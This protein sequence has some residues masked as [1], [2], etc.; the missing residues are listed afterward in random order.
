MSQTLYKTPFSP[1]Y[2]RDALADFKKPRTLVFSALMVA[3]CVALSYL[4][5]IPIVDNVRVTWGFLARALCA[6]VGGPVNALA[7]TPST[8]SPPCWG[9]S[10]TRCSSTGRR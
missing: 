5:S 3:A 1:A 8:S 10:P 2:W 9:C 7:T 6:L 4:K